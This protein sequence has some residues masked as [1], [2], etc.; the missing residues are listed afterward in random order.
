MSHHLDSP[1]ARQDVRLDITDLYVFRGETGT[2]FV[3]DVCPSIAGE[4]APKGFHPEALYEFKI[5]GDGDHVED[6][7]YRLTFGEREAEGNQDLELHRL[8][9]AEA[10]DAGASGDVVARG[11]TGRRIDT[12][13]GLRL[14]VGKTSDPFWIEPDALAAIGKAFADGTRAD[15]SSWDPAGAK[16][17]FVENRVY[18][19]V[20][21]VPDGDLLPVAGDDR[22]VD[23]WALTSLATDDGGWHAVNR[24]GHPMVHPLFT[25]H[26]GDL[27]DQLNLSRPADDFRHFGKIVADMVAGVVGAYGTAEDPHVY[28]GL[29]ADRLFPN[30]LPYTVGTPAVYG[31]AGWN[32]RSLTDNAPDVMFSFA[33][34][35]AFTIG[36][37]SDSVAARPTRTFPYVPS[38]T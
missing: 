9:G 30:V 28:G 20:L 38:V 15:L 7:T 18:A 17:L 22:H 24:A 1:I 16:N 11:T 4:S 2:V 10:R 21:E 14:W 5:D 25:Q 3:M 35:T 33:T 23:V 19:I 32:G 34:N 13:G 6:L 37:G 12:D 29:V 26:D 27:G 31:F 8:A 36:L